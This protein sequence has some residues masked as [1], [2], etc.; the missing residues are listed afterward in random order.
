MDFVSAVFTS[1]FEIF[2]VA[3]PFVVFLPQWLMMKRTRT[4]GSF[5]PLVCYILIISALLRVVFWFGQKFNTF[6]FFQAVI[7]LIVQTFMLKKYFEVTALAQHNPKIAEVSPLMVA[8]TKMNEV[9]AKVAVGY[10]LYFVAFMLL[11]S[12]WFIEMTGFLSA[13]VEACLPLPQFWNNL[14]RHSVEGLRRVN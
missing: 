12:D 4:A 2:L 6:I 7:M 10:M 8:T 11:R 3:S 14:K 13:G 9:L 1:G 5:S